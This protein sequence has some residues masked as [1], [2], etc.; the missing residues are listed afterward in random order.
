MKIVK[1]NNQKFLSFKILNEI[2]GLRHF[3]TTRYGGVSFGNY[4]SLNLSLKVN[5]KPENVIEN[6]KRIASKLG[7]S[8]NNLIF[9]DQ[10]HTDNVKI[11]EDDWERMDVSKT[12]ALVTD[13]SRICLYILTADCVPILLYDQEKKVIASVHA[14]W[15]GTVSRIVSRTIDQMIKN[16]T[17]YPHDII[18]GI[19]PA[20]S[21]KYYEVGE[22]VATQFYFLFG[23]HPEI[24][25]KNP[26]TE[27][28]HIDL[29]LANKILLLRSG[30]IENHIETI[31]LCTYEN[32]ELFFSARR[33]G[34]QCGRFGT[35]IMLI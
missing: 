20:I 18:A 17:S 29:Q 13:K 24:L 28:V 8:E 22:D 32:S 12:D 16:Y 30:L 10:C 14:G 33:D 6:R 34:I 1:N 31:R 26:R 19:G 4:E 25:W 3:I 21:Q 35:G 5:D 15:R 27:K 11:I 23:D 2:N 9:P 7:I